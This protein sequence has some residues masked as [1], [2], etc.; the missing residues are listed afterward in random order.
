MHFGHV[1]VRKYSQSGQMHLI[2]S[3]NESIHARAGSVFCCKLNEQVTNEEL[4]VVGQR[5]AESGD[6]FVSK[7][8]KRDRDI[9]LPAASESSCQLK[10]THETRRRLTASVGSVREAYGASARTCHSHHQ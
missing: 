7:I 6:A 10:D 4:Q 2:G 8:I 3:A 9:T 5:V 1:I